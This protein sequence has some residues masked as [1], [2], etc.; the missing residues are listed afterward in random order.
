[1]VVDSNQLPPVWTGGG[2]RKQE[3]WKPEVDRWCRVWG[4]PAGGPG[5][6]FGHYGI[7][8]AELCCWPH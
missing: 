1:M 2:S 4:W 3:C 5:L 7:T 6:P 8:V